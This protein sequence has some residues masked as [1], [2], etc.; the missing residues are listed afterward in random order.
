M[1]IIPAIDIIGGSCVRLTQ[2]QYQEKTIYS[3]DVLSLAKHY[4]Q[5]GIQYL[6]LVDLDAAKEKRLVNIS[7][8]QSICEETNLIVDYGGG[9]TSAEDINKLFDLGV[10]QV[11][12]GSMA[13]KD[14]SRF[15]KWLYRFGPEKIVLSADVKNGKIKTDAWTHQ[16]DIALIN[17]IKFAQNQGLQ[18]VTCTDIAKDGLLKGPSLELYQEI[19]EQ[20]DIKLI[21]SGGVISEED[22]IQLKEIGCEGV[23]I[24]KAIY[25]NYLTVPQISRLC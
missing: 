18:Y 5:H 14:S 1:R 7:L 3:S 17:F 12:I 22:V 9:I 23:I 6:H 13:V 2:G 10:S 19:A 20:C 21:A 4:E 11:N 15:F 24:G 25:E 16:T 8:I